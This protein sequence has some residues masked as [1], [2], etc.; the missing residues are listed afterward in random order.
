MASDPITSRQINGE[1]MEAVRDFLGGEGS[2]ITA[3]FDCSHE[4]KI[5][6]SLEEKL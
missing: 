2:E 1:T 3:D 4:I 5:C 6:C